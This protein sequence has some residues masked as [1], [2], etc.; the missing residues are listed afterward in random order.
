MGHRLAVI[1]SEEIH[2]YLDRQFLFNILAGFTHSELVKYDGTE[3]E[4]K[5]SRLD[6]CY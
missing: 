6:F 1:S 4:V 5:K 2:A 3:G